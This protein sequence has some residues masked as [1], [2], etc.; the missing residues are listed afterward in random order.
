[1]IKKLILPLITLYSLAYAATDVWKA[2]VSVD[3]VTQNINDLNYT[4]LAIIS[5]NGDDDA[6]NTKAI[7]LLPMNTKFIEANV[8]NIALDEYKNDVNKTER[9]KNDAKKTNC[10]ESKSNETYLKENSYVEC[11]LGQLSTLANITI[12][13]KSEFIDANRTSTDSCSAFVFS[14]SPDGDLS[15]NYRASE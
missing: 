4:C 5:N 9:V 7:I 6:R 3:K 2:D 15:N 12:E 14:L 13:I 1:M 10:I 11:S 8:E